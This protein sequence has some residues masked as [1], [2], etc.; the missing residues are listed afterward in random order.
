MEK[1]NFKSSVLKITFLFWMLLTALFVLFLAQT[2]EDRSGQ[3]RENVVA[4]NEIEQLAA[5]PDNAALQ[6]AIGDLEERLILESEQENG[7]SAMRA[8]LT[9]YLMVCAFLFLIFLYIEMVILKPFRRLEDFA[10]QVAEGN[11]DIPLVYERKNLF[12]AFTW[13][14]DSMRLEIKRARSCEK[15]AIENNK[16]VIATISHDIKTPIASIRA[17]CE[18]LQAGL[19]L[20]PE[21]KDRYLRVILKKCDEVSTLTNDLFLHSLSDLDKLQM[22]YEICD[23]DKLIP[24]ILEGIVSRNAKIC[25]MGEIP[26]CRIN[27]DAKRLEQIYENLV[28]NAVK[29]APGSK[30]E[31]FHVKHQEWLEVTVR[32]YGQGIADEDLPFIYDKFYR[33]RNT[34]D[35]PGAGLGL[36]IVQYILSQLNREIELNNREEGLDATFRL[37]ILLLDQL[38][39]S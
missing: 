33:G 28:A 27:V 15:A 25:L 26:F 9:L 11:L 23:A 7:N 39:I 31:V 13:A 35:K 34:A 16:T 10:G 17:Y 3:K 21:R 37:K 14:F 12:G 20:N 6:K 19:D 32:D 8:L 38:K 36:Y 24:T 5:Q 4:L 18:A 1:R 30:V 29:Y 2:Y 22:N